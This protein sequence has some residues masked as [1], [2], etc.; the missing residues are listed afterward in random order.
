MIQG[1]LLLL[2]RRLRKE[3]LY[4]VIKIAG[5]AT[6]FACTFL[7]YIFVAEELRF[8]RHNDRYEELYRITQIPRDGTDLEP[9]A[10]TP[11]PLQTL[12]YEQYDH[13]ISH[14][15]RLFNNRLP[16]VSMNYVEGD[17]QFYESRFFFADST[18]FDIFEVRFLQGD[19]NR[20]LAQPDGLVIT[21]ETAQR[22]FG[23]ENPIGK[24]IRFEGRFDLTVTG[25]IEPQPETSHVQWDM[26]A[27]MEAL[28]GLFQGGIPPFWDWSIVWTYVRTHPGV[29]QEALDVALE[30]I[31]MDVEERLG[32]SPTWFTSQP[33]T[34]IRLR[35]N[36][37]AE[38]G[39][40]SSV[41][42]VHILMYIALFIL[43][44]AVINFINLSLAT[45]STRTL[46]VG[47]RKV[48]GADK[49]QIFTQYMSEALVTGMLAMIS[50]VLLLLFIFPWYGDITGRSTDFS[51][52]L[53]GFFWLFA[54]GVTIG[55]STISG[56]YP[57]IVLSSWSPLA[58][59]ERQRQENSAGN[60]LSRALIV[61]QFAVA[62]FLIAGTWIV[63]TQLD[64][65]RNQ[66]LGFDQEQTVVIPAGFT[67][68]IFYYDSFKQQTTQHP[69]ILEVI[70]SN[71]IIGTETQTFGYRIDGVNNAE[72]TSYPVFLVT[73]G[74]EQV[75]G[76]ELLA[77]RP[78]S[79]DFINDATESV[80]VNERFVRRMGWSDPNDAVGRIIRRDGFRF[81]V[82]GVLPDFNI[83]SLHREIE[84]VVFE[85][86]KNIPAQIGYVMVK[87]RP[88]D[89]SGALRALE[90]AWVEVDPN[91]PFE[92][93]FLDERIEQQYQNEQ[94]LARVTGFFAIIA[95]LLSCFGLFGLASYATMRKKRSIGIRKVLG[96]S[97][98]NLILLQSRE[99]LML[100]VLANLVAIPL[101]FWVMGSWLEG[102]AYRIAIGY[103]L[104]LSTF[105]ITLI[106]A[107]ISVAW[108]TTK[109]ALQNPVDSIQ[110]N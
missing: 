100:V 40:V 77:G 32:S 98:S 38:I 9:A 99:F 10:I 82:I 34:D 78:F 52:L 89:P 45:S 29:S 39:P 21:R 33:I 62:A 109:A 48:L 103:G 24:R 101:I 97:V 13:V 27:S 91:R 6:A 102:F 55:A 84:P 50:A 72:E 87:V 30:S 90:E 59:F 1:F 11:F 31:S 22:Y 35:S 95:I 60:Y 83:T 49:K 76:I 44:I 47:M 26:L 19:A 28:G 56:I 108:Q 18:L 81:E 46:E 16:R 69:D 80:I 58:L 85:L 88:G 92:F 75:L 12:L 25:V 2:S 54:F 94:Q 14:A 68:M 57:S 20:A 70:G 61:V 79:V 3:L 66:R 5:V 51:V 96:A 37:Y 104:I 42:Y 64:F 23:N 7:M 8:D 93:F 17:R 67:R 105:L 36:L 71:V 63:F 106:I 74:F 107:F 15:A 110:R 43:S 4:T 86:A 65:M 41:Q 53:D 73:E